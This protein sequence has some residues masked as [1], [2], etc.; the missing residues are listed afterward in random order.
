MV[1]QERPLRLY[2]N[3]SDLAP[4]AWS[5]VEDQLAA[6]GTYWVVARG[7]GHPHPRPVWGL[8]HHERLHLS[9]GSPTLVATARDDP[10]VTVHLESGTDVVIVEGFATVG[11]ETG[12]E[13]L[14]AYRR[15]YDWEYDV[16]QYGA[17]TRV[18]PSKILAWRSAGWAGRDSFET[19]GCWTFPAPPAHA[20]RADDA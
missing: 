19:T 17:L 14:A 3:P 11:A 15:K 10:T 18:V 8:W 12:P 20:D 16:A 2:R 4:L 9:I 13:L 6:S 1:R 5:W 7:P